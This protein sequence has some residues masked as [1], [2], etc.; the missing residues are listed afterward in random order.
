MNFMKFMIFKVLYKRSIVI[1]KLRIF[2]LIKF[3]N[4][5]L[6]NDALNVFVA[7]L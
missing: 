3:A 5:R 7:F 2:F 6:R 1:K 4:M